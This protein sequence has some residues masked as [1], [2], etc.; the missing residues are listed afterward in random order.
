MSPDIGHVM[1]EEL[2]S[3]EEQ[4]IKQLKVVRSTLDTI[5]RR[6]LHKQLLNPLGELQSVATI[7]DCQVASL[8]TLQ[9]IM[10]KCK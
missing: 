2:N 1:Q 8:G 3:L 9:S 7:L 5:E 6:I 4:C 10:Y